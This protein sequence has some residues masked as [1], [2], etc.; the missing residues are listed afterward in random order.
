MNRKDFFK[1]VFS[2]SPS[3]TLI[4]VT[5]NANWGPLST[6]FRGT[7]FPTAHTLAFITMGR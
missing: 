3:I 4:A 5:N 1:T 7:G 6:I 2:I